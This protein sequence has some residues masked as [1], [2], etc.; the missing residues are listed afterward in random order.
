MLK[1]SVLL[2]FRRI[3]SGT[4]S[5][6]WVWSVYGAIMFTVAF[7]TAFVLALILNCRPIKAYWMAFDIEWSKQHAYS[8]AA[9][10]SIN[11]IAGILSLASD[12]YSLVLP[13]CM[14]QGLEMPRRQKIGL[15]VVF[16]LSL[17]VVGAGAARTWAFTKFASDP[18]MTWAGFWV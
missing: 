6:R 13:C 7:T 3:Q 4:F 18:D 1:V 14:V 11:L 8:C 5:R 16:L 10:G 15:N 17:R 9:T 2:F 12:I